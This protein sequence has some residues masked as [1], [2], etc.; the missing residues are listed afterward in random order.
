MYLRSGK[1]GILQKRSQHCSAGNFFVCMPVSFSADLEIVLLVHTK[2]K[3]LSFFIQRRERKSPSSRSPVLNKF[4]KCTYDPLGCSCVRKKP[5]KRGLRGARRGSQEN[6]RG[7]RSP[8]L[9][10]GSQNASAL[11]RAEPGK[12]GRCG[13]RKVPGMERRFAAS[14]HLPG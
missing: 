7:M 4:I 1:I 10:S 8:R 9:S 11:S 13:Q 12:L 6:T 3:H 2:C 14:A 5:L